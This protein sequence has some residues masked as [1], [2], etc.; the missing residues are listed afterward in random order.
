M[1]TWV[2]A[3]IGVAA[4]AVVCM[5][6][7][8][9]T[10]G[11]FIFRSLEQQSASEAA[12]LLEI[13][14]IRTRYGSRPPLIEIIDPRAMD[15]RIN[16]LAAPDAARVSTLHV[17]NW[18]H[19]DGEIVRTEVPL[20]LMRF[21]S[22]NVLSQLGIAPSKIRLTVQD[23]QRYGPGIVIDYHQPGNMRLLIWVD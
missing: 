4:L 2:K 7:L 11:Y 9:G 1:R 8:G 12:A 19:E 14:G 22:L 20:W 6:A 5:A 3:T 23:V 15:V 21:S 13:D 10:A 17:V 16:R 18:K